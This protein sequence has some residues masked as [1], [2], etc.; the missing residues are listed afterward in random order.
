MQC[1][2]NSNA[3]EKRTNIQAGNRSMRELSFRDL[4]RASNNTVHTPE[5]D[6]DR[7]QSEVLR[8]RRHRLWS[9]ITGGGALTRVRALACEGNPTTEARR[10]DV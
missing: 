2:F 10:G 5:D 6:A 7:Y 1:K 3:D 4:L 9:N 8:F